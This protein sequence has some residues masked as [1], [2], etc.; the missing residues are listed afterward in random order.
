VR[1]RLTEDGEVSI[2][3]RP[4]H[5]VCE[6]ILAVP[7][8]GVFP[9]LTSIRS[10]PVLLPDGR[11]L[12]NNGYDHESGVLLRLQ[13]LDDLRTDMPMPE[14]KA[15]LFRELLG[16]FPFVDEASRAHTA[17]L[18]LEP[19]VRPRIKGPT[20]LYLID[21]PVR[22]NGKGLLSDTTCLLTTGRKADVM[23]LVHGNAEEHEKRIT[24]LLLAGAPWILLD[25]VIR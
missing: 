19:F 15:W 6:S 17:A 13:G 3:D 22:G 2:P 10:V 4:P 21:S 9:Q 14:A 11:L 16:D 8:Q 5:D 1:V 18:L 23:A 24:A 12:A 20:P 25:N 7:P